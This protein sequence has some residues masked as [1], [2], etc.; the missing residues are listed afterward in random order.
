[1]EPNLA[2]KRELVSLQMH[3]NELHANV[4]RLAAQP[5]QLQKHLD[6]LLSSVNT[7]LVQ[8]A[9][10]ISSRP[11]RDKIDKM[12]AE[13]KDD[14]P[15]SRLMALQRM[16]IVDNY[17][18]IR[19]KTVA[20]VG[21]GGVGSVAAEMMTRCG[22]G[23]LL[24]YDYDSVE[25]ANMNR[26]FFRPEQ[27][28]MT[29]TDA[30]IQTLA[31]INPD[32]K[33]EGYTSN[34]CTVDGFDGFI[35]SLKGRDG[36]SRVDL[37]LSCVD[38]YEARMVVNQAA[39]EM[40][41]VWMESGVSE[42]AVSGHIQLLLPGE[43]ACF[44]CAP[45]LVVASGIDEKTLKREGVCAA[46]LP[47]TMGIVAGML[48]QNTL[49]FLLK[50]GT[51]SRYLGYSAMKDFFPTMEMKPNVECT[52]SHCRK[53]QDAYHTRINSP[54]AKAAA[55][56]ATQA[57]ALAAAAEAAIPLHDDNEWCISVCDAEGETQVAGATVEASRVLPEGLQ[58]SM[59]TASVIDTATLKDSAVAVDDGESLDDLM[60]QMQSLG[61]K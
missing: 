15:Y 61:A 50:F 21:I 39:L 33:L 36:K 29:K 16:G 20:I 43:T 14:N 11:A 45:P 12:S 26:L 23:G 42:D 28:G 24:L 34:I 13:V 9:P 44:E 55:L 5:M 46:S 31:D 51:V 37:I 4:A 1:M 53:Q 58:F 47:T 35:K 19:A 40:D 57:A 7:A 6:G 59:P 3:L 18:E 60:A 2:V 17:E 56:A 27:A 49:K 48:V 25:L 10:E 52:N 22:V 38:N 54:E 32:V 30:A 41:Q 8:V